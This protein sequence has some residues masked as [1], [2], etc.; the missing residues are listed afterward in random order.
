MES[1]SKNTRYLIVSLIFVLILCI[2]VFT[3]QAVLMRE[4]SAET[5]S[6]IGGIY[7]SGM[8][9]HVAEHFGATIGLRLAQVGDLVE[10]VPPGNV[11]NV[12]MMRVTLAHNGRVREFSS[13]ALVSEDG[14]YEMIYGN[15]A[16]PTN[17]DAFMRS[18]RSGH[19]K[20][21]AATDRLGDMVILMGMPAV[22]PMKKGGE[23]I[24]LVAGLPISYIGETL[25]L[26]INDTSMEY[27]MI[28]KNGDFIYRGD[29]LDGGNYFERV[30]KR[31]DSVLGMEKEDFIKELQGAMEV[32]EEYDIEFTLEGERRHMYCT[33]LPNSEWYLLVGMSYNLMD[34][35]IDRF[36]NQWTVTALADCALIVLAMLLVF[37][38]Y[39]R[40][41]RQQMNSLDEARKA[42]ERASKA[43]SEFLSNM[44]H[45]IRTPMNGIVG[46]TTIA[47]SNIEDTQQVQNCLKKIAFSSGHLLGMINDIMDMSKIENGE[48]ILNVE[49]LS[50]R[51][52]MLNIVGI[53]RPQVK[54]KKQK[55]DVYVRDVTV[56]NVCGDSVRI[57]QILLNLLSNAV[58][59]TPEEG[60]IQLVLQEEPSP[61]G[62]SY[63]RVHLRVKDNG[64]GMTQ[65][66]KDRIFESFIREDH[67]RVEK[68]AGAGLGLTITKHIVEAMGGSIKVESEP[69][70][71][72]AFHI[73]VDMEKATVQEREMELP[74][75]DLLIV[76]D[77]EIHCENDLASLR[78]TGVKADWALNGQKALEAV[79]KRLEQ[80]ESYFAILLDYDMPGMNGI[81]TAREIR[82]L[83]G[84]KTPFL[85]LAAFDWSEVEA[86]AKAV[87]IYGFLAKPLFK[88]TL[89]YGLKPLAVTME[90]E[91][92]AEVEL[93]AQFAG[94]RAL[95]A[96][97]NE[98]NWE[99]ASELISDLGIE[100]DWAE[101]GKICADMFEQ[102]PLHYYDVILMDLRMPVMTGYEAARAIR[103][104]DR[105]DADTIP[106]IAMSADA[107]RDDVQKCLDCGMNAHVPKP[108]DMQ[109][110]TRLLEKYLQP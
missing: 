16:D 85:L 80:G 74:D 21:A 68:T 4:K 69:G 13:L 79:K 56:E 58:K 2:F 71:G 109:E 32:N 60:R 17:P 36:G 54:E 6:D 22:Y 63:I 19:S 78:A 102:S 96:E 93:T 49:Q 37:A 82:T 67:S 7:M 35:T 65:E 86:E 3:F 77:D 26:S 92:P 55:L 76:D 101:D 57:N 59:F 94:K 52:V 81:E 99:I 105:E 107:Y 47:I 103:D 24:A 5:I 62:D 11:S 38:G 100:L 104:M 40:L 33:R 53:M 34:E 31:Y 43:K 41:M 44:S 27:Y 75:W 110:V 95:L 98:L 88:S 70:R 28:F 48:L 18:L 90:E 50:L 39:F 108:I 64:V 91:S 51:D 87:G 106:I 97:D 8:G 20:I 9:D 25:A 1:K 42:A 45:D 14:R 83:C 73:T 89:F 10:S 30:R 46:M 66:L 61:R 12:D 23:S 84:D 72:S 29:G 15:D